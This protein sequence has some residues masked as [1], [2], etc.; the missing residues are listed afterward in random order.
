MSHTGDPNDSKMAFL[1]ERYLCAW[2]WGAV[3][4][5]SSVLQTTCTPP[6]LRPHCVAR[7]SLRANV[8]GD[9][10]LRWAKT[11]QHIYTRVYTWSGSRR[12]EKFKRHVQQGTVRTS[13]PSLAGVCSLCEEEGG[14]SLLG[15]MSSGAGVALLQTVLTRK[16]GQ[17]GK[18][19]YTSQ[20]F[21]SMCLPT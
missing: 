20:P 10:F 16:R 8:R 3:R 19:K 6:G 18:E 4:Q 21:T 12:R 15:C 9:L 13:H 17:T 1:P 7:G 5:S 2:S 14:Q 11:G